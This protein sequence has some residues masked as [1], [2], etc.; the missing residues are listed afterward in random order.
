MEEGEG[1]NEGKFTHMEESGNL[2]TPWAG[3]S[4]I[5]LRSVGYMFHL[6]VK[7]TISIFIAY[8]LGHGNAKSY[9]SREDKNN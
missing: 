3:S 8:L 1:G 2:Q 4:F 7:S 5:K 6:I 9:V